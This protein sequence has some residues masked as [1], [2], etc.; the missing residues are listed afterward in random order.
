MDV[1]A[2]IDEIQRSPQYD[3]QIVYVHES[4]ERPAEFDAG[5][6]IP[7]LGEAGR[8]ILER[9]GIQRLYSHQAQALHAYA[10]GRDVLITT[11]TASGK[12]LC[13][14]VPVIYE[15]LSDS[16][17]RALM[18]FPTKALSQDQFGK[19]SK[20][21]RGAGLDDRLAG[22]FDGDTPSDLRRR[23]RDRGSAVITNPDML[24]AALMPQH[25]RWSE[26]LSNLKIIVIDELHTYSG[27]FGS[28]VALLFKRLLRLCRYY[29]SWP[30][31]VACSATIGNPR[32]LAAGL[33]GRSFELI[34]RD[35]SPRGARTYVLWNPPSIRSGEWR[36][37]RSANV[38]AH[39][40]MAALVARGVPTITFSKA[41]M[42]AEMIHRYVCDKLRETAPGKVGKVTPYRGGYQ[43]GERREIEKRL[44]NGELLGVSTTRAL[45]LG[46]DVGGIEASV[47]V[48]YP[49]TLASFFQ[50]SGRAGRGEEPALIILIGVDTSV[51]QYI[52][53]NPEYLFE[54]MIEQAVIDPGNP[55]VAIGHLRCA[56]HELPLAASEVPAFGSYADIA[57]KVLNDNQKVQYLEEQWYHASPEVPHHEVAL[58]DYASC[59]VLIQDV[60]SG[61]VLGEVNQYDAEPILHPEA[62]YMHRG[63]TYRVLNLDLER[64]LA[65][66]RK[67]VVDYYTQPLGGT[68]IHHVDEQLR[69]KPFGNGTV[70]WGEVTA[71]FNTGAYEKIH[72]YSLDAI[73]VHDLE[74]PTMVLETM[75]FWIVPSDE[76]MES[77]SAR[78]FNVHSGLRGI[79]YATRMLLPLFMTCDTLD[80]SHTV[81]SVNSPWQAVFVYERY[82]HGLGFTL[83][84]FERMH[85][86]L[87]VVRDKI[88]ACP[89]EEGC[90]CC[91]GKPLRGYTTWNI[92][93]GE[94]SIPSKAAALAILDGVLEDESRLEADEPQSLSVDTVA[95]RLRLEQALRRRLERMREPQ[96]F[97]PIRPRPQVE[98]RYP[99]IEAQ[100]E[101]GK[102]D[103]SRRRQKRRTFDRD[104][105]KRIAKKI[106]LDGLH[107]YK[108]APPPP[109]GM[110][111]GRE[112]LR[113]TA[114]PGRPTMDRPPTE[115]VRN[116][117]ETPTVAKEQQLPTKGIIRMGDAIAAKALKMKAARKR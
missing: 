73:S 44:F 10:A 4:P 35:A 116:E 43:P 84:A 98:T 109:A 113:P 60:E 54:R 1:K 22:V 18:L 97:H 80:F 53:S 17:A 117:P 96:V 88:R 95:D 81:G 3:G 33:T 66:V 72:F 41:K 86:I 34:D 28:N 82:P 61:Q 111:P 55:F 52:M 114:F 20:V 14:S 15:F 92:E 59:N 99:H 21:L 70:Y 24:H 2:F 47:I 31:I 89:C 68:D 19:F 26:F 93:R 25:P 83:K 39:E 46:I 102:A 64:N 30:R 36:S 13:Y 48:G 5:D 11:G 107:P 112:N 57:L 6:E 78:D 71:Y 90:P 23:L 56:T 62:I 27:I 74:L 40:L 75:A 106:G 29:G 101:L 9:I 50:Q 7:L 110:A 69:E 38:E 65:T 8:A 49:G 85:E 16:A 51:N 67:V 79:G 104:L 94:A 91:V 32:E 42:T 76:V 77:V 12:T 63:D 58:R 45:E 115:S 37:R 105:H 100:S 87:P 108:G 103:V